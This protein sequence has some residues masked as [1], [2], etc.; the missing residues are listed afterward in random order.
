MVT[1][2]F[3]SSKAHS[4]ALPKAYYESFKNLLLCSGPPRTDHLCICS[5]VVLAMSTY[6]IASTFIGVEMRARLQQP[7]ALKNT[8]SC[9]LLKIAKNKVCPHVKMQCYVSNTE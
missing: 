8:L 9:I 3:K 5:A 4:H 7:D 2:I 6:T 1:R